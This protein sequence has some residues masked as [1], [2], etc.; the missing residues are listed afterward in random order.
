MFSR[1]L[2]TNRTK[3]NKIKQKK[4]RLNKNNKINKK[5]EAKAGFCVSPVPRVVKL[6]TSGT[7]VARQACEQPCPAPEDWA[8]AA[9][10]LG[11][12][13]RSVAWAW[14]NSEPKK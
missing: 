1:G 6:G 10:V 5:G 2:Q 12:F 4:T 8:G 13:W 14:R 7:R 11:F 3:K 9:R